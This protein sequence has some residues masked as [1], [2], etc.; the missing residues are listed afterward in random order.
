MQFKDY[1]KIMGV[2]ED[3]SADDIKKAYRTL[4]R[5][6]HPD[7]NK[8]ADSA[9][10]FRELGEAYEVLKDPAKRAEYDQLRKYGASAGGEFK[11]PPGWQSGADF[12]RGGFTTADSADFSDFFE[13]IFGH[14]GARTAGTGAGTGGGTRRGGTTFAIRGE[15]VHY[16]IPVTLEEAFNGSTRA[17]SLQT[18]RYDGEGRA[19]PE[20]KT[21]NVKIPKGVIQG[22]NI[23]LRGQGGAGFGGAPN[24]D[25]YME[26][27]L[28]PHAWF[29]V[30]GRD[31]TLVLP[32]TPWEAALGASVK[33]PTLGGNVNLTIPPNAQS[34]QKLRLKGRGLPGSPPGDQYVLLQ[35]VLPPVDN[36]DDRALM[37]KMRQQMPFNPRATLGV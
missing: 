17:I 18:H 12:S 22:Q 31:V 29:T 9:D 26:V 25:L 20:T 36:A 2:P 4:A 15:D 10:K 23:R 28:E 8:G 33:V 16:R 1:Y 35:I 27:D 19:V 11:P 3:A 7:L 34:G 14:R 5:K 13:S 37:E 32:V 21:L 24:G 6:H 30:D